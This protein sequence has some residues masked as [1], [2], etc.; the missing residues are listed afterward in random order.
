PTR[1]LAA[2]LAADVAGYSKLMGEDETGTLAALRELR[3]GLFQPAVTEHRGEVVKSMGDGWLVEFASVVDAVNC[4]LQVQEILANHQIIKLRIGIHIGDIVHEDEDIYGDGVNISARLQEIAEPGGVALSGRAR[5]FLDGK[6]ANVFR[7]VGEKQLKNIA[8][9]VRVFVS[10]DDEPDQT[11]SV[12]AALPLP[13]KPSIAVL[14][15]DN[16]S[17]DPEQEYFSDGMTEDII[18]ALSRLR[19][20]FVIARNS[21][22][23]YKGRAVDIKVVGHEM[24]V[25]YV[26]EGSVRKSGQRV[27]VTAQ[28]IEAETGNHI[29][30]ER[31]DRELVDIFDLQD[32]LT[33][34]ISSQV[35]AELAGREREQAHKKSTTNLDAWELYQRGM[36][37][38]YKNSKDDIAEARRLFQLA[39]VQAPDF[40]NSYA[41]LAAVAFN[42]SVF[43]YTQDNTAT[44]EQGMRDAEKAISL[45][46]RDSMNHGVLGMICTFLGDHDRAIPA[47]EKAIELNPSYAQ[48]YHSLG[49]ALYWFGRAEEAVPLFARAIRLSPYDPM[50]W[51]FHFIRGT[52]NFVLDEYDLAT[53]DTKTATQV[54][55]DEFWPYLTLAC[56][57][58]RS[59]KNDEAR[60]AYERARQLNSGLSAAHIKALIGTLHPPYLEKILAALRQL[61]LPE[62]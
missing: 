57:M 53:I 29:W 7:D 42:E 58:F 47:L 52:V 14:P 37:H 8:D 44:L 54:K 55:G 16:M 5:D 22:F 50:L 51:T 18:T 39:S 17:G 4:A 41:G 2:I 49:L 3:N 61:G 62:E 43:G 9:A 40:A 12:E 31:Y 38:F 26:L 60:T 36:W 34:A 48:S 24:G 28:L 21:S 13:D 11:P 30:A 15:F 19:W 59:G 23:T 10:G 46:N 6:L 45:D 20:L 56:A 1:K 27:R 25:R 32:E 35:D 33:E